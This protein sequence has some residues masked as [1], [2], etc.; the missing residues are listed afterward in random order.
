MQE[1]VLDVPAKSNNQQM[2]P[3]PNIACVLKPT[4]ASPMHMATSPKNKS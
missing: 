2:K 1:A 3:K 4:F